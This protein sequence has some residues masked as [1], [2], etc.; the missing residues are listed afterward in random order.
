MIYRIEDLESLSDTLRACLA[1]A[2]VKNTRHI[3]EK[4]A[5]AK[6]RALLARESGIS[7]ANILHCVHVADLLRVKGVGDA[8]AALLLAAGVTSVAALKAADA[9]ALAPQLAAAKAKV[10]RAYRSPTVKDITRWIEDAA[11]LTPVFT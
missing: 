4:C 7:E 1:D 6:G 10:K 2:G 11:S 3:L 9:V 5:T 8:F